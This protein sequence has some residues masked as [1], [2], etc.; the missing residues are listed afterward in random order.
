MPQI[1]EFKTERYIVRDPYHDGEVCSGL[2][3]EF[4]K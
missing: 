3:I 2:K 1:T 4:S